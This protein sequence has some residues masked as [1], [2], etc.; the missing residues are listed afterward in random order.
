MWSTFIGRLANGPLRAE[1]N[2]GL[3]PA[4]RRRTRAERTLLRLEIL[5]DRTVLSGSF[6][7]LVVFGDSLAD[8]GNLFLATGGTIPNPALY[9][10]GHFSNGPIWV[11]TLAHYLGEP[12]NQPSLAGGLDFAFGGATVV[13]PSTGVPTLAEQVGQYLAGHTPASDDVVAVW[14]GAND[15]F[16]TFGAVD[17]QVSAAAVVASLET[18]ADA[19]ARRFVVN[20]LPPLGETPFMR[21]DFPSFRT[22]A[23]AWAVAFNAALSADLSRFAADPSYPGV[24]VVPFDAAGLFQEAIGEGDPFGFVNTTDPVGPLDSVTGQTPTAITAIT[25]P[26]YRDYLFFDGVHPTA[27][28]HRLIG[29][30]ATGELFDALDVH[31]LVVTGTADTVDP[32]AS[33]TSLREMLDLSNAMT[34]HQ[35][36]TF[37]LGSG[38]QQIRLTGGELSVSGDVAV[39]GPGDGSLSV[40]GEGVSRILAVSAHAHAA[41]SGVGLIDGRSDRG[42]AVY[43]AGDL[44]LSGVTVRDDTAEIGGGIYNTGTLHVTASRLLDNTST[45][46]CL[47]AGGALANSGPS[48]SADLDGTTLTGNSARGG[49]R[50][51][52]GAIA[53]LAGA[54]LTVT[55]TALVGNEVEGPEAW[56]GGVFNEAWLTV[57]LSLLI[58]NEAEAPASGSGLGG[59]VYL[60]RAGQAALLASVIAGN[61]ATTGG[62]DVYRA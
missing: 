44:Q 39:R 45:G 25:A 28:A 52:G 18:L 36:V 16:D 19:G 48:A 2:D 3:A 9:S 23:D 17:P 40:S 8:A 43:N 62:Q 32:A 5:E 34:G 4:A 12:V 61:H 27:K 50:S 53:N 59:G 57:S 51:E 33:T 60:A 55:F 1:R 7:H 31:D 49:S 6:G 29:V 47:A 56:G 46:G 10:G 13:A 30:Q 38:A 37:R 21:I 42:G 24:V 22:G 20:N 58:D 14:A 54:R 26:D 11:D 41:L 15:F 35:T